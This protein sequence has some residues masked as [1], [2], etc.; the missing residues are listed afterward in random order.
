MAYEEAA[1]FQIAA[2][3]PA[4]DRIKKW[5][6]VNMLSSSTEFSLFIT[7]K[8]YVGRDKTDTTINTDKI[9]KQNYSF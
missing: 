9:N 1:K 7:V 3:F 5:A 8:L 6:A 4:R 2:I